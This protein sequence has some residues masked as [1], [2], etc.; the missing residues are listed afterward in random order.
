MILRLKLRNWKSHR[1]SEFVFSKG[2]NALFGI[3]GSGKSSAMDAMSFALFGTFPLLSQRKLKLDDLVRSRPKQAQAAEVELDFTDGSDVYTAFRRLEREKGTTTSELRKNGELLEGPSSQRVTEYIGRLLD[4]DYDLFSRAV[5]SEQNQLDYFLNI[6]KGQRMARID[7]LLRIDRFE[8]AR[9]TAGSVANALGESAL[10]KERLAKD[11]ITEEGK[12]AVSA[13][14]EEIQVLENTEQEIGTAL[15]SVKEK[16]TNLGEKLRE[17]EETRSEKTELEKNLEGKKGQ[18]SQ[19]TGTIETLKKELEELKKELD[20][21]IKDERGEEEKTAKLELDGLKTSHMSPE[22]VSEKIKELEKDV[23]DIEK[24]LA[25]ISVKTEDSEKI[26]TELGDKDKCPLCSS[27]LKG[28]TKEDLLSNHRAKI[29]ALGIERTGLL[30]A[31]TENDAK[32]EELEE[33]LEKFSSLEKTLESINA[34]KEQATKFQEEK[35]SRAKGLEKKIAD[36]QKG[37]ERLLEDKKQLEDQLSQMTFNDEK[38]SALRKEYDETNGRKEKLTAEIN[39][40][41]E[42]REEKTKRLEEHAKKQELKEQYEKEQELTRSLGK[43]ME[44]FQKALKRTQESLREEF[45]EGVNWAMDE[46]WGTL[47]PYSDIETVKLAV[48]GG[49]YVLKAHTTAGTYDV[50]GRASGGERSMACMA[51]RIAFSLALA[52]NL[53]WLILDEPTHNLD[54]ASIDELGATLMGRLPKLIDQIFLITHEERLEGAVSGHLYK[55]ERDK[56]IDEPTKVSL[57]SEPET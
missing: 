45:I 20:A 22:A 47:Y 1:D 34:E 7:K 41:R 28:K 29:E 16:T 42:L 52:P 40:K 12:L 44:I 6:P 48:E 55:L 37:L 3:M 27:E 2:V 11:L 43:N 32:K 15:E 31:K 21:P 54:T 38:L 25:A 13:L 10:A 26:L 9:K 33:I 4:I 46:I 36:D 39:G 56:N 24:D 5:Y 19:A 50:E 8:T 18:A 57:I 53:S 23:L 51:L 35:T 17:L 30:K 49:D 14:Q